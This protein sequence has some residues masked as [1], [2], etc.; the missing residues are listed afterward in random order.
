MGKVI[1]LNNIFSS[2]KKERIFLRLG[3][4]QK[5]TK[6]NQRDLAMIENAIQTGLNLCHN[7]GAYVRLEIENRTETEVSCNG[8][9]FQSLSL[10]KLLSNSMELVLMGVTIGPEIGQRV[11][12]E[13]LKGDA[14]LGVILDATASQA[15]DAILDWMMD[16]INNILNKEGKRL[17]K[18]RYSPGYGDLPLENQKQI[19]EQL[20]L[21]KLGMQLTDSL[22]LIPEKSVL[23]ITGIERIGIN[24]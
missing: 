16:F 6:I 11:S 7:Q 14:T 2:P 23:A 24:E 5:T 17:T 1:Y 22:M 15:A 20:R 12:E 8:C 21:E 19:F 4:H 10:A 13:I 3:Y 18:H 9:C